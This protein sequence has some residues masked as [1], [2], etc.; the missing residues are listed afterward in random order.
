MDQVTTQSAEGPRRSSF[1]GQAL[2]CA[3]GGI[4]L[5]L[6][7]VLYGSWRTQCAHDHEHAQR[8]NDGGQVKSLLCSIQQYSE[9]HNGWYPPDLA[10]LVEEDYLCPSKV[11]VSPGS[12]TPVPSSAADVRNGKCD[13]HYFGKG[14]KLVSVSDAAAVPIIATKS[15]VR[16][17]DFICVGY[18]DGSV[19]SLLGVPYMIKKLIERSHTIKKSERTMKPKNEA[20]KAE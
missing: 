2:A 7:G 9:D 11:F 4:I 16:Q 18:S 12:P 8:L 13:Y 14:M 10:S 3:F 5:L 15:G 17:G 1:F 20:E 6:I 19:H